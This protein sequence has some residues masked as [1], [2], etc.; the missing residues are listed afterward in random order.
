MH[1]DESRLYF[2]HGLIVGLLNDSNRGVWLSE[3][4]ESD[5]SNDLCRTVFSAI[6]RLFMK[7]APIEA[8][9]VYE[10]ATSGEPSQVLLDF[11]SDAQLR[12]VPDMRYY[13]DVLKE[14]AL[15]EGIRDKAQA[16][17][18]CGAD[19][20]ARIIGEING[21]MVKKRDRQGVGFSDASQM[22]FDNLNHSY[23]PLLRWD[24][25]I[26]DD[27][28]R[29]SRGDFIAIGAHPSVGKTLFATQ[30]ALRFAKQGLRVG[31]FSLETSPEKL[32]ERIFSQLAQVDYS[33]IQTHRIDQWEMKRLMR[34]AEELN[35]ICFEQIPASGWTVDDIRAYSLAKR[36]DVIFIDYLQLV[37][38]NGGS[39]F[40]VVTNVSLDLHTMSQSTGIVVI[41]LAQFS[42]SDMKDGKPVPPSM[43]SFRES[44]QIEQDVDAALLL[45]LCDPA[46][47]NGDRYL[48]I[49]KNKN[50]VCD[51]CVLVFDGEHQS[52]YSKRDGEPSK[53]KR[54][55]AIKN[56]VKFEELPDDGEEIPFGG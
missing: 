7:R 27:N 20:A 3:L 44:G 23:S 29:I 18:Y 47:R 13:I 56:Q 52:M 37:R 28:L 5:F 46:D 39:R 16:L 36:F 12:S 31:F 22:F 24:I 17:N 8:V 2:E 53:P 25:G 38:A 21:L 14:K 4:S 51:R 32:T 10:A 6:K 1:E 45:Y 33:H 41:A 55:Q 26:L 49:G 43:S 48:K 35:D 50:G 40:E 30:E 15:L 11:I 54:A 19:E 42:R 9:T 34:V